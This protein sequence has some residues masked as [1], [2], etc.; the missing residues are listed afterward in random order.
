MLDSAQLGE[1]FPEVKL[2][3][4]QAVLTLSYDRGDQ[5]YYIFLSFSEH[6]ESVNLPPGSGTW[7]LRLNSAA[8]LWDGPGWN[9]PETFASGS[10]LAIPSMAC[11][12][13]SRTK[14]LL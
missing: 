8:G 5:Q 14:E 10:A 7:R 4:E 13:F 6:P 9:M 1:Y 11:V 12:V 3:E 2:L